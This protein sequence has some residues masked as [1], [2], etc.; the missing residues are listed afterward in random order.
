MVEDQL[1]AQEGLGLVV[2]KFLGLFYASDGMVGFLDPEWLQGDLNML[3]GLFRRY[4]LVV[5]ITKSKAMTCQ[6]S[7]LRYRMLEE[8]AGKWCTVRGETHQEWLIQ[9][10]LCLECRVELTKGLMTAQRRCMNGKEPEIDWNQLLVIQIEH[11]QQVFDAIF[12]KGT[13]K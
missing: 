11:I 5:N 3:I 6:L 7:T 10:I 12:M 2:G 9:R 4:G 1:V 13:Y 8:E